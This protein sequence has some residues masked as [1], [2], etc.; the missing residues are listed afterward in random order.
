M[1][2]ANGKIYKITNCVD[3]EVYVGSTTQSLSRRFSKHKIDCNKRNNNIH[4]HFDKIGIHNFCIS[5]LE[6]YPC[7]TKSELLLREGHYIRE[8]ATLNARI[9]GRTNKEYY[10][11]N[12]EKIAEYYQDNKE[13]RTEYKKEYYQENK[14]KQ[15]KKVECEVCKSIVSYTNLLRHQKTLKCQS[16]HSL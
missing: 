3:N 16:S 11:D 7:T 9:E 8:L 12:K 1:D 14:E 6:N 4:T 10:Q 15:L 2:Y 5:L 13:K